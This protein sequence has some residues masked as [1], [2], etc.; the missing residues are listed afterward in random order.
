MGIGIA[1]IQDAGGLVRYQSARSERA[2]CEG[3][4]P[5]AI[6]QRLRPIG[7]ISWPFSAAEVVNAGAAIFVFYLIGTFRRRGA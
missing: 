3:I 4:Y 6:A 5:S 7:S 1:G 2:L